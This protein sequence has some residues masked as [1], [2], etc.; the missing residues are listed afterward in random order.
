MKSCKKIL[1]I[2]PSWIG[3]L[4]I[5]QSFFKQ[6]KLQNQNSTIDVVIRSNLIT[7]AGMMPEI[8][9]KFILD[10]SHGSFGFIKRY[11]LSK[12][13]KKY[14]YNEAYIL[15]NSF[16]SAI[17]PW[18]ASIPIRIGYL[19][20]MR[21]G[22]I[23]KI[24]S[25]KKFELPMV[26]RFLKL[27][28]SVYQEELAPELKLDTVKHQEINQ[29]FKINKNDK[30]VFLCPDAE[31][32]E[33]KRW[34]IKKW[35]ELANKLNEMKYRIYFLG[36]CDKINSHINDISSKSFSIVSLINKTTVEEAIY[37]LAS[38]SLVISNDSGLMHIA[39]SVNT[40]VIAIFG[41]SSPKYTPPLSKE[42]YSKIAYSNLSCSPC[43][44]RTCPLGHL[45]CLNSISTEEI[46]M[47]ADNFL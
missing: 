23:N 38:S 33:A 45:N 12:E 9:K 31:Y 17:I 11:R 22:L 32:G 1:V 15:T 40:K 30:N 28:D 36:K 29:K 14:S 2:A 5:S 10:V 41:S 37:L 27:I 21:Y 35:C 46:L 13:L 43:F 16:K 26:N 4:I 24:F 8:D 18:L 6:L 25:E 20:E 19:G 47:K 42:G 44:Q 7:I 34:P 3:D 39:S